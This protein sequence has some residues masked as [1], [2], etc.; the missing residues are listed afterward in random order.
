MS[1]KILY[2]YNS[3]QIFEILNE[4]KEELNFEIRHIDEKDYKKLSLNEIG[5]NLIVTTGKNLNIKNCIIIDNLPE[6][7][8]KVIEKI[9]LGFLRNQFSSQSELKIGKYNLDL[10][11][12]KITNG[13][14]EVS[15]TE[16]ETELIIFFKLNKFVSLKDLQKKVWKHTSELETHTVETHIYRLRKKI[17]Q[18]FND[19]NFIISQK[20]GYQIS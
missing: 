15:L 9:N 12:R 4:I 3:Y 5:S 8:S 1:S 6:K 11:S 18:T 16:K 13:E 14:N 19:N 2:I 7:L 10:N 20:N 17:L